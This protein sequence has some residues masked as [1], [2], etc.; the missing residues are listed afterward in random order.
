M[1]IHENYSLK[2]FNSFH[3]DVKAKYFV[4]IKSI[5]DIEAILA[6]DKLKGIPQL[7]IGQGSNLLFCSDYEGL[8]IQ[9]SIQLRTIVEENE[10]YKIRVGAGEIW[11]DIVKWTV[12]QN[13]GGMENLALIP[14]RVGAAPIQNIGAYGVE[15][16]DI[17]DYVEAYNIETKAVEILNVEECE[18][19]YRESIFKSK[20]LKSHIVTHI[21]LVLSKKWKPNLSYGPLQEL[22][23]STINPKIIFD[24]VIEVR[25]SKL[26]DPSNI[27]NAGS[28]FKN[29]IIKNDQAN[30][31]KKQFPTIPIYPSIEGSSKVAAGWLIDQAGLKGKII[32]GAR[33][34]EKQALVITN[35]DNASPTDIV[36]LAKFIVNKVNEIF[37]IELEHEVRFIKLNREVKLAEI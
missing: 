30:E 7:V 32:G 33:V 26:P 37:N 3:L 11:H 20:F 25:N 31:L 22:N 4:Q 18:F 10:N 1:Q 21:G 24:K 2:E 16:K 35:H 13:I 8:I 5:V 29:P 27:G 36:N 23:S 17:C 34:Y 6:N 12:E 28:F 15:F 19:S 9:N 14:G